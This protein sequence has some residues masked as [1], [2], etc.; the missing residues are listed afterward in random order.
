M[1]HENNENNRVPDRKSLSNWELER[2][3]ARAVAEHKLAVPG[4]TVVVAV[5][6]GPDSVALLHL[7]AAL[8]GE[9]GI[10]LVVAHLNHRFRGAESDAEAAF[11]AAL[12]AELALPC[13]SA[14][15]DVPALIA[16]SGDNT[17][18][19]ARE[20][21]YA[22]LHEAAARH[23][24]SRVAL[25]HH[26]D[27]QA[28]TVL[29][30][31]LRG[32]GASGL[33]GMAFAR[34][35][36][37]VELIRPLLRIY[38]EDLLAYNEANGFAFCRDSSNDKRQYTRNRLRLDVMPRLLTFNPRLPETLVRLSDVL[39]QED[40][41]LDREAKIAFARIVSRGP[42][43]GGAAL[44]RSDFAALHVALQRRL[45]KL[46]LTYLASDTGSLDYIRLELVRTAILHEKPTTWRHAVGE[47]VVVYREYEAIR[48]A[49]GSAA[50]A[51]FCARL[52]SDGGEV[53]LPQ[54]GMRLTATASGQPPAGRHGKYSATFDLEALHFP[55]SVR[56]REDGDRIAVIGLNGT[57]KVKDIFIDEKV[58]PRLR[59]R[60]PLLVD[61]AGRVLWIPGYR[62]SAHARASERTTR[63]FHIAA[64]PTGNEDEAVES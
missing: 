5:S 1:E 9:F 41:Y 32:A 61:A 17:Q 7:L 57:K 33:R 25:A 48:F 60:I 40:D 56:S 62:L 6:G 63:F 19:A 12:A 24:A 28:E 38:K 10:R 8:A 23:G 34:R 18:A 51:L 30:R 2:K 45:I 16:A 44:E 47:R 35:D 42:E 11:V 53:P 59:N 54:A 22:F 50:E 55:L 15:V 36:K 21:R 52:D 39:S 43:Q 31:L 27:D 26:A 58:P 64:E 3:V 49:C 29:M 13:E 4:D 37:N 20:A 46:I 14:A